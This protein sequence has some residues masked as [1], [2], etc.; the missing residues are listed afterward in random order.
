L[1]PD[2]QIYASD[3]S[4]KSFSKILYFDGIW[5]HLKLKKSKL[6][7]SK[8]KKI[9]LKKF[10]IV[11]FTAISFNLSRGGH[12][13]LD[14]YQLPYCDHFVLQYFTFIAYGLISPFSQ[15]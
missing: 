1:R 9:K 6:K 13:R 10:A 3:A 7:K 5:S 8:L 14:K 4:Q 15:D 11:Y 12:I 2:S